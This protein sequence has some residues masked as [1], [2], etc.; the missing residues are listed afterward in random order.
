MVYRWYWGPPIA[1]LFSHL[2]EVSQ[3]SAVQIQRGLFVDC[4]E[5]FPFSSMFFVHL[6]CTFL[7][8][9]TNLFSQY[10]LWGYHQGP[11]AVNFDKFY[12]TEPRSNRKQG[13][14]FGLQLW[15]PWQLHQKGLFCGVMIA[16][17][18]KKYGML[19]SILSH[20]PS[21]NTWWVIS[22]RYIGKNCSPVGC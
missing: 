21:C 7:V 16:V 22:P 18:R 4:D 12:G 15:I 1:K 13:Q 19:S 5:L 8:S 20:G 3:A 6:S 14:R 10:Y 11:F 17:R 9:L 2:L